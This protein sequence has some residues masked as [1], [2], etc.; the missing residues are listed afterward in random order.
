MSIKI[1]LKYQKY[2]LCREYGFINKYIIYILS[3]LLYILYLLCNKK[4]QLNLQYHLIINLLI[5]FC[6]IDL[7]LKVTTV[8]K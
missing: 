5:M 3:S 6:I 4:F 8:I 7:H 1:Y 2:S